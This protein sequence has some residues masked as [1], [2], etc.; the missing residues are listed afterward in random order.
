VTK[1]QAP[2]LP[3][4]YARF[5]NGEIPE[6]WTLIGSLDSGNRLTL[7]AGSMLIS[8]YRFDGNYTAE[9][10]VTD[11]ASGGKAGA[12]FSYTD[13]NNFGTLLFDPVS[14]KVIVTITVNGVSTVKEFNTIRSFGEKTRFDCLQAIQIEKNGST[15]TF[16]MNDRLLGSMESN[17]ASG[18]IGYVSMDAPATFGF[19]GG[20]GAVGGMGAS[21]EYKSV[22]DTN[23][24]IPANTYIEGS[25]A[26]VEKDQ[27]IAVVAKTNDAL[28][29]R[30]LAH[31][32]GFY[33]LSVRYFGS[34][35]TIGIYIDGE[36]QATMTLEAR[37]TWGTTILRKLSLTEGAHTISLVIESGN[38]N[39][40]QYELLWNAEVKPMNK[41]YSVSFDSTVYTEGN[42]KLQNGVLA[43]T[44]ANCSKRLYGDKNWGDYTVEA[45]I[46]PVDRINCG[47]LVRTTNPGASNFQFNSPTTGDTLTGTD[48]FMGYFVG[49]TSDAGLIIGKHS[50]SYQQ[51]ASVPFKFQTGVTYRLKAVCEGA[52]IKVYINGTLYIDYTDSDPFMQGMVGL[53]THQCAANFDN[54]IVTPLN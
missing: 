11:I 26:R 52:N 9:Y 2:S 54:F 53:R 45:D 10:N 19:I 18:A 49:L 51:V 43:H 36:R 33:D 42:W 12:V 44:T 17:L 32:S 1:Q 30:V 8:D 34:G 15:Y 28:S 5:A 29:Y 7:S 21:D 23:G 6:S 48:W 3:D 20:T 24:L 38:A 25:F 14:Q 50:Y 22:S 27:L 13:E 35:A 16:Y 46:T 31:K 37:N 47:I 40:L 39:L 4:V 41:D